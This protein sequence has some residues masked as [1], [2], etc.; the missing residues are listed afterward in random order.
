MLSIQ[1]R[2]KSDII[3]CSVR[4]GNRERERNAV[5]ILHTK[6]VFRWY[7]PHTFSFSFFEL[8]MRFKM[9]ALNLSNIL[10]IVFRFY[11]FCSVIAKHEIYQPTC[12]RFMFFSWKKNPYLKLHRKTLKNTEI[13]KLVNESF[14]VIN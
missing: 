9:Y 3:S 12:C 6:K 7:F 11:F 8:N 10:A 5:E 13:I 2:E 1:L 14:S 4:E